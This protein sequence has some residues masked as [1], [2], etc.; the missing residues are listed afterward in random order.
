M[1]FQ[2]LGVS[3]LHLL[4]LGQSISHSGPWGAGLHRRGQGVGIRLALAPGGPILGGRWPKIEQ[5]QQYRQPA[6]M[7]SKHNHSFPCTSQSLLRA[8]CCWW[9]AVHA[10]SRRLKGLSGQ[11]VPGDC[12]SGGASCEGPLDARLGTWALF[13]GYKRSLHMCWWQSR[14]VSQ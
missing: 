6:Q 3:S 8:C 11:R 9:G 4:P 1:G 10:S 2:G 7:C 5:Y 14:W 12:E 13:L